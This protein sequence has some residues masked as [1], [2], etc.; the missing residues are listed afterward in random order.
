[1]CLGILGLRLT[2]MQ[3]L[4]GLKIQRVAGSRRGRTEGQK[5]A[6]IL[7]KRRWRSEIACGISREKTNKAGNV[8]S[9]VFTP[10][11]ISNTAT[12]PMI[13]QGRG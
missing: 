5:E 2:T 10:R 1:M 9:G 3:I 8:S 7:A 12:A 11:E 4:H 13:L 6:P